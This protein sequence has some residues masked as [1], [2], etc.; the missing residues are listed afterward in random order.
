M[1]QA[2]LEQHLALAERHIVEGENTVVRQRELVARLAK[3]R[4]DHR[5]AQKLLIEFETMLASHMAD[6]DRIRTELAAMI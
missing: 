6:R 5:L 1:D 3:K 2:I 4:L